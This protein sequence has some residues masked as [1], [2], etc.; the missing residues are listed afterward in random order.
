MNNSFG[1]ESELD[2]LIKYSGWLGRIMMIFRRRPFWNFHE[3]S[4][5]NINETARYAENLPHVRN[6]TVLNYFFQRGLIADER[7]KAS[8][9]V[10]KEKTDT[11]RFQIDYSTFFFLLSFY[12]VTITINFFLF[13]ISGDRMKK[14]LKVWMEFW[15]NNFCSWS[16]RIVQ[17]DVVDEWWR[18]WRSDWES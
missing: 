9:F 16:W 3:N 7:A 12:L 18:M 15:R 17:F 10:R 5:R 2:R 13:S 4:W 8:W 11:V 1:R 14:T 6:E